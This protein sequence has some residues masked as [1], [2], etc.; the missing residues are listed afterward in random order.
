MTAVALAAVAYSVAGAAE[1]S[2]I[3]ETR[4]KAAIATGDLIAHYNGNR[5]VILAADLVAYIESLPTERAS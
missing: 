5:P 1:A 2:S 4:I 3:G